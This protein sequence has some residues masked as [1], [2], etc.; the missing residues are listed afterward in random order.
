MGITTTSV[1]IQIAKEFNAEQWKNVFG[2]RREG[3]ESSVW[4]TRY[5]GVQEFLQR[6]VLRSANA[7]EYERR[8]RS[9]LQ[10]RDSDAA[11]GRT[12]DAWA[13]F[14]DTFKLPLEDIPKTLK[15]GETG[16][17][18]GWPS[19]MMGKIAFERLHDKGITKASQL[20]QVANSMDHDAFHEQF[21]GNGNVFPIRYAGAYLYLVRC[22]TSNRDNI[23][24]YQRRLAGQNLS[25]HVPLIHTPTAPNLPTW[26]TTV[27]PEHNGPTFKQTAFQN[28]TVLFR[29]NRIPVG[30]GLSVIVFVASV[31]A[32]ALAG[33]V[34]FSPVARFVTISIGLR[35]VTPQSLGR[36]AC[37]AAYAVLALIFA[38]LV[39]NIFMIDSPVGFLATFA[40]IYAFVDHFEKIPSILFPTFLR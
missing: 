5:A 37:Q 27:G 23:V 36:C 9:A 6:L 4:P 33:D 24:E 14:A 2:G 32:A 22:V 26:K 13:V 25:H 11:T 20:V 34:M 1:L 39:E 12:T 38:T 29:K 7:S 19:G 10:N 16:E 3:C 35:A 18:Y 15:R 28:L 40:C 30:L 21:G 8:R 31:V 17:S